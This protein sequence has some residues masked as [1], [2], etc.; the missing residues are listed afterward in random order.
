M[1][2]N[3]R[4]A[5]AVVLSV[6]C[7]LL[8]GAAALLG[9]RLLG[10]AETNYSNVGWAS[11]LIQMAFTGLL[12]VTFGALAGAVG[13]W[14]FAPREREVVPEVLA[15]A[16]IVAMLVSAMPLGLFLSLLPF[17][18]GLSLNAATLV[19]LLLAGGWLATRIK[20]PTPGP[21]WRTAR[22]GAGLL[23][24][25]TLA[26]GGYVLTLP[27]FP[28]GEAP[29]AVRDAWGRR[30]FDE[31]YK[32]AGEFLAAA[33]VVRAQ[34]G[35]P[36]GYAPMAG[37]NRTTYTPGERM[38]EFTLEVVGPKGRGIA[39]LRFMHGNGGH[40]Y[41]SYGFRGRLEANHQIFQIP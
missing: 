2:P 10:A 36:S 28:G 30:T 6:A 17:Y 5:V 41:E 39:R 31:P 4:D 29:F 23:G 20:R 8:G 19:L 7:A 22:A 1:S 13:P 40:D 21:A 37:I 35:Q 12:A 32:L 27:D 16:V 38:G 34:L 33:P 18:L 15:F 24:L 3:Q 9:D 26:A 11:V 25:A 14:L